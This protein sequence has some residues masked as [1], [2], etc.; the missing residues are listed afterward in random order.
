M[1][2]QDGREWKSRWLR[3][4]FGSGNSRAELIRHPERGLSAEGAQEK[5]LYPRFQQVHSQ[6]GGRGRAYSKSNNVNKHTRPRKSL[7]RP[8][9][10]PELGGGVGG[11]NNSSNS[12]GSVGKPRSS[13]NMRRTSR[14]SR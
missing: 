6:L 9:E 2:V 14:Q 3:R 12:S 11:M 5:A 1:A 8:E 4:R 10:F 7:P 13:Q